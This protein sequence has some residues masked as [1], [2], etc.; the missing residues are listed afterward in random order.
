MSM[1]EQQAQVPEPHPARHVF[2]TKGL[3]ALTLVI[4]GAF[5]GTVYLAQEALRSSQ[6]AAVI[7][8]TLV[9]LANDDRGEEDLGSL[10]VNPKLVA[11]AQAKADDMV[12]N[13]YF[14]HN[15]PDGKTSW[16]WFAQENYSFSYA[17]ENLAVNFSD[18]EDVE[19][20]WMKSPTH[21]ANIMNGK[22][23]EIGIATAVGK[24]EGKET[25]FVVQMF[26]TPRAS[27]ATPRTIT[28]TE[29]PED[30]AIATTEPEPIRVEETADAPV[31]TE[32]TVLAD[33]GDS[34]TRYATPLESLIASPHGFLRTIYIVSALIIILALLFTTRLEI[35]H[36]HT[37]H[38]VAAT[39]LILLMSG[40][41]LTADYLVF[42]DPILTK[43]PLIQMGG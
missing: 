31:P 35:A 9:D 38:V 14:A 2:S 20:A 34:V 15:S 23:T 4:L 19:R 10:T 12:K 16:Y 18:S 6:M 21:R 17:G 8:A 22:F 26:G 13:G 27:A 24:Y 7:S 43:A 1:A 3:A 32:P 36:H 28:T 39:C 11:A 5:A 42:S 29:A 30:I 40:L 25:V 33:S 37:R 41:F